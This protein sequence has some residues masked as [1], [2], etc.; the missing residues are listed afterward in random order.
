[1]LG[2]GSPHQDSPP[3]AGEIDAA[4]AT[5]LAL[6][7][8][9]LAGAAS[10][11]LRLALSAASLQLDPSCVSALRERV[12]ALADVG[13]A[14]HARELLRDLAVEPR[15]ADWG[16][17]ALADLAEI[18]LELNERPIASEMA[19]MAAR[20]GDQETSD[21]RLLARVQ[22]VFGRILIA[23]GA[24]TDAASHLK[25]AAEAAPDWVDG[26]AWL[27]HAHQLAGAAEMAQEVLM[28]AVSRGAANTH[29]YRHLA[30][31]DRARGK[32]ELAR[33]WLLRAAI[34]GDTGAVQDLCAHEGWPDPG[35]ARA[36]AASGVT[37][38]DCRETD[39]GPSLREVLAWYLYAHAR[40]L[41]F[42]NPARAARHLQAARELMPEE[43]HV[44]RDL[45]IAL[46]ASG[47]T[48]G[49]ARELV[50]AAT[51]FRSLPDSLEASLVA[52]KLL[53]RAGDTE[54]ALETTAGARARW[55]RLGEEAPAYARAFAATEMLAAGKPDAGLQ[56]LA[57][58][59][60]MDPV[61]PTIACYYIEALMA[62]G[63]RSRAIAVAKRHLSDQSS[64]RVLWLVVGLLGGPAGMQ[65]P[66]E[67]AYLGLRAQAGDL[68]ASWLVEQRDRGE[69]RERG[70]GSR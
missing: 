60:R 34:E 52:A 21:P 39:T 1:M 65:E 38:A 13:R 15:I 43:P 55:P 40:S 8:G 27:A 12:Y 17:D 69:T 26:W 63:R 2:P 9:A 56:M 44:H 68:I 14:E 24:H 25:Q 35:L 66:L 19:S 49:A 4:L 45:G 70:P 11:D 54:L 42:A 32:C 48:R 62:A 16:P 18:A 30:R 20:L 47:D 6:F 59:H 7:A 58:A 3:D 5:G 28:R 57:E 67:T 23:Q 29:I 36:Q 53:V 10:G 51:H 37:T 50:V 31:L 22:V 33:K 46:E 61:D 64:P 41:L